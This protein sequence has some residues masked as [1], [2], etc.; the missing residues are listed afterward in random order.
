MACALGSAEPAEIDALNILQA[1]RLA[2]KRAVEGLKVRPQHLLVDAV[3][4]PRVKLPQLHLIKGDQ[5][6]A[7]IAAASVLAKVTR[8]NIMVELDSLYP[9]YRFAQNKG[10]GTS[11]HLQV[12]RRLG[13][14]PIHRRSFAPVGENSPGAAD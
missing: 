6:S 13:P 8:D 4:L 5:R 14:C 12:L 2:M 9:E 3:D 10:Y 11:D 1:T 7:S